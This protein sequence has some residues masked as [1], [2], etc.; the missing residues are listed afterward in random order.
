MVTAEA[1][2]LQALCLDLVQPDRRVRA[3]VVDEAG[4]SLGLFQHGRLSTRGGRRLYSTS[5]G[6]ADT[7]VSP[8]LTGSRSSSVL[9][10]KFSVCYLSGARFST[11][12]EMSFTRAAWGPL[13]SGSVEVVVLRQDCLVLPSHTRQVLGQCSCTLA[14]FRYFHRYKLSR[15][16]AWSSSS[17]CRGSPNPSSRRRGWRQPSSQYQ[18]RSSP[19]HARESQGLLNHHSACV[20]DVGCSLAL[21]FSTRRPKFLKK[22]SCMLV[23]TL[24]GGLSS[25]LPTAQPTRK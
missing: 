16:S 8:L 21:S 1:R 14:V 15:R 9:S 23:D 24:S 10:D 19:L 20:L 18:S 6:H 22:H 2:A 17:C 7:R 4:G 3:A 5:S 13:L 25:Q 11:T 12:A